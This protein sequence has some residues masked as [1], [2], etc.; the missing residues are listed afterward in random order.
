M[1]TLWAPWRVEY[2]LMDK[3]RNGRCV[4]CDA[5]KETDGLTLY[6]GDTTLVVMT[7][8]PY[9][10]GHL[11]VLPMRHVAELSDLDRAEIR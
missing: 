10:N 11:L 4:F 6:K 1:E 2:I 5:L 3:P 9:A 8:F 7:R